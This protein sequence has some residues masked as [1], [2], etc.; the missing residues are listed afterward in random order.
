[1]EEESSQPQP[2]S[3]TSLQ[4]NQASQ[5]TKERHSFDDETGDT[6]NSRFAKD[7]SNNSRSRAQTQL[8]TLVG[9]KKLRGHNLGQSSY[10]PGQYAQPAKKASPAALP[11]DPSILNQMKDQLEETMIVEEENIVDLHSDFIGKFIKSI[12]EDSVAYQT[13]QQEGNNS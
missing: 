6:D 13:L 9:G 7:V 4:P 12:G 8:N 11:D 5:F 2:F 3:R 1:M 10:S